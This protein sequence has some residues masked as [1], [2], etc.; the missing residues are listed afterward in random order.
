MTS[1]YRAFSRR[2]LEAMNLDAIH[3]E[4]YAF[5]IEMAYRVM[6]AGLNV[7][8]IAIVFTERAHGESKMSHG[9][10]REAVVL[11][12][13]LKLDDIGHMILRAMGIRKRAIG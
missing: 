5:Q 6:S 8:E 10:I 1:G 9:I 3:S 13:R 2:A 12:W 11:P 7:E 4:G